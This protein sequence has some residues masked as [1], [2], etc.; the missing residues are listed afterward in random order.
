MATSAPDGTSDSG[1]GPDAA[2]K[3]DVKRRFKEALDRKQGRHADAAAA[4]EGG[5]HA[6]VTGGAHGPAAQQRQFRRKSGG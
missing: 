6:K 5:E 2:A 4:G 3:D 1:A